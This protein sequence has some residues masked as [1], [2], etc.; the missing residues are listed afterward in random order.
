MANGNA[1]LTDWKGVNKGFT[2]HEHLSTQELT[3][4]NGR[5]YD[6]NLG[7]FLSVDPFLQFPENSQSANPYSYILNNPMS[8]TDPT[9]YS[10]CSLEEDQSCLDKANNGESITIK[11]KDGKKVG[12]VTTSRDSRSANKFTKV[13]TFKGVGKQAQVVNGELQGSDIKQNRIKNLENGEMG[14]VNAIVLHQTEAN[15]GQSTI[16]SW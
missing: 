12:T 5:I 2:G 4:M 8:E 13:S 14:D 11:D 15:T 3:H 6:F 10:S 9:G 16:N 1:L 7:R